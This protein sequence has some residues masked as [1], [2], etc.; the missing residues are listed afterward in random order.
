MYSLKNIIEI[1]KEKIICKKLYAVIHIDEINE[2]FNLFSTN[3]SKKCVGNILLD[4][5]KY[6]VVGLHSIDNILIECKG[7]ISTKELKKEEIEEIVS[8]INKQ[9]LHNFSEYISRKI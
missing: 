3:L 7:E 9:S 2:N 6:R 5:F 8:F 1:K 4:I